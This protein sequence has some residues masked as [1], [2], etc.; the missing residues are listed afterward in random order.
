MGYMSQLIDDIQGGSGGTN[1]TGVDSVLAG[2]PTPNKINSSDFLRA[3]PSTQNMILQGMQEKY[4]LDPNDSL[5]QIKNTLPSFTAPS[6]FGT[7]KG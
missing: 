2:I 1:S 4:G 3:A 7:I 6:T 5:Q